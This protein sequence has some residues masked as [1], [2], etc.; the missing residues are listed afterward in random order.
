MTSAVIAKLIAMNPKEVK[1]TQRQ[2]N[3][4]DAHC[5]LPISSPGNL[6][7]YRIYFYQ[8]EDIFLD[9]KK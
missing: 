5:D 6:G 2:T 3:G 1:N 9:A 4:I 7:S 8:I